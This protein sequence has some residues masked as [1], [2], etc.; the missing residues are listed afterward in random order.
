MKELFI[1]LQGRT[2]QKGGSSLDPQ[3]VITSKL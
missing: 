1:V 3:L 2:V